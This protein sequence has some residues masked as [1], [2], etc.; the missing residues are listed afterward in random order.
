M[1]FT[2]EPN[3]QPYVPSLNEIAEYHEHQASWFPDGKDAQWHLQAAKRL[4]EIIDG[5][6]PDTRS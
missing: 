4:R 1:P 3:G 2:L 5:P 6:V